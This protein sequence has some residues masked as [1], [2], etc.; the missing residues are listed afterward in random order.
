MVTQLR[1]VDRTGL[2]SR[3]IG[4]VGVGH[5]GEKSDSRIRR[6]DVSNLVDEGAARRRAVGTE[7]SNRAMISAVIAFRIID[8]KGVTPIFPAAKT[9]R[10]VPKASRIAPIGVRMRKIRPSGISETLGSEAVPLEGVANIGVPSCGAPAIVRIRELPGGIGIGR[11]DER[12]R[13]RPSGLEDETLRLFEP[14]RQGTVRNDLAAHETRH[15]RL[16]R[17]TRPVRRR[18]SR[19]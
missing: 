3:H 14:E 8:G 18:P 16:D 6:R 4:G 17:P 2:A 19:I 5:D 11:R 1:F 15:E 12:D 9:A 7:Q 10:P 13:D